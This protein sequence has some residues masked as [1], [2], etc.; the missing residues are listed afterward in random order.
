M[1]KTIR[2]FKSLRIAVLTISDSRTEDAD[3]SGKILVERLTVAGHR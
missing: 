1:S 2:D 3:T